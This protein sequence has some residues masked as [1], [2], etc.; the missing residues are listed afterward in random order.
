[1]VIPCILLVCLL[2][3]L[4]PILWIDSQNENVQVVVLSQNL[5]VLMASTYVEITVSS[6]LLLAETLVI[7]A[8]FFFVRAVPKH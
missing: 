4:S 2:H 8:S 5:S 1:M 6:H 3:L 7:V